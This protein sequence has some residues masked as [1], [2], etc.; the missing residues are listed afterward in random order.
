MTDMTIEQFCDQFGACLAGRE[1][2]LATG[3]TMM[4][5]VWRRKDLRH[6]WRM[7]IITRPGVATDRDLRLFACRCTRDV[8]HLLTDERS[9]NA[10]RVAEKY[11]C[12]LATDAELASARA[13]AWNAASDAAW[14]AAWNAA[15]DAASDAA[16]AAAW[17]AA[18]AAASDAAG[19]AARDAA[20]AA[21]R[22]A[23]GAAARDA[24]RDAAGDAAGDAAWAKQTRRMLRIWPQPFVAMEGEQM[25]TYTV[26]WADDHLRDVTDVSV[27]LSQDGALTFSETCVGID[28]EEWM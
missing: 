1:W 9:R 11:A 2:A 14:N 23:A 17:D 8:W 19:A 15:S 28:P 25:N 4:S 18:W 10:V 24:T 5:E 13:A 26:L 16:W 3:C 12:G 27:V 6:D 21:A 20:R 7:W 22:A